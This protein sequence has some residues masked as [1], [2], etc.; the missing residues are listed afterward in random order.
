MSGRGNVKPTKNVENI[1]VRKLNI[2]FNGSL[3]DATDV[4]DT[5]VYRSM[6]SLSD[7]GVTGAVGLF[8]S[9]IGF[10]LVITVNAI[11]RK[12]DADSALF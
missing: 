10:I 2:L 3:F 12:L 5:Y 7:Y 1:K 8:Q 11:T 6:M 9:V 4:I